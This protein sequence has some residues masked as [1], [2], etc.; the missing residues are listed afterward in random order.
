MDF[1]NLLEKLE[2]F[3]SPYKGLRSCFPFSPKDA[4]AIEQLIAKFF[5]HPLQQ[6][7]E[8]DVMN[9]VRFMDAMNKLLLNKNLPAI[10]LAQTR[11]EGK[12]IRFVYEFVT[13]D[14]M[15]SDL[16]NPQKSGLLTHVC[17]ML[18]EATND[19]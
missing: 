17:T 10:L 13:K 5:V 18:M 15:P 6:G 8:L 3:F 12:I 4:K 19:L 11:I 7:K 14:I 9:Q 16:K 1:Q 2:T